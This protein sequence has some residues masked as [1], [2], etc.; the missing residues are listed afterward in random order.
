MTKK[1][2]FSIATCLL[3]S[4]AGYSQ[5]VT[6]VLTDGISDGHLKTQMES[7]ISR[8]LT[9][10]NN[11]CDQGSRKINYSGINIIDSASHAIGT[12]WDQFHFKTENKRYAS[13]CVKLSGNEVIYHQGNI[14]VN[15]I[16]VAGNNYSG[17]PRREISIYLDKNG[18]I[19]DFAFSKEI[20]EY[21]QVMKKGDTLG[22]LDKRMQII[23]WCQY[24]QQAYCD[25]DIKFIDDVFSEDALILVGKLTTTRKRINDRVVIKTESTYKQLSKEEYIDNLQSTFNR[26]GYVN[27][28]FDDFQVVRHG[29]NPN[30]YGVTL[31]QTWRSTTYSD[32]GILF[33]IWDFTDEDNPKIHVRVWQNPKQDRFELGDFEIPKTNQ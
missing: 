33:L 15:V 2:F 30:F 9:A 23:E 25:K 4:A 21:E 12:Y 32:T 17:P 31:K 1:I 11:A 16:P 24:L 10:I 20:F 8:L 13:F 26:N 19:V 28:K 18:K 6:Y 29:T 3:M 7:N 14:G 22:D 27:V 5:N